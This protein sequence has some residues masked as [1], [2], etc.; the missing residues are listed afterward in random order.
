M[1]NSPKQLVTFILTASSVCSLLA[2]VSPP[3]EN[4]EVSRKYQEICEQLYV[5]VSNRLYS[6]NAVAATPVFSSLTTL[7]TPHGNRKVWKPPVRSRIL[8]I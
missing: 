8:T 1:V 7:G 3:P 6:E 5:S 2:N 4:L